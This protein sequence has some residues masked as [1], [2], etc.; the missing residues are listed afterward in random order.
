MAFDAPTGTFRARDGTDLF[1][2]LWEA[3]DPKGWLLA[4]HGLGAHGGWY[5]SLA[6]FLLPRGL[7]TVAFDMRGHG[8]TRWP[9]ASLPSPRRAREDASEIFEALRRRAGPTPVGGVGTSLGGAVLL[10]AMAAGAP[11]AGGVLLSPAMKQRFLPPGEMARIAC[12]LPFGRRAGFPTPLARGLPL[13][14]DAGKQRALHEDRLALRRLPT[15]SWIQA[16]RM[17]AA[18]RKAIDGVRRPLLVIQAGDDEVIDGLE[19]E[20]LFSARENV[21]W[22]SWPGAHDVKLAGDVGDLAGAVAD[23]W[24]GSFLRG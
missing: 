1:Y 11:A 4:L 14:R 24:N 8:L 12:G 19:N 21:T 22:R 10:S 16:A 23:W 20:R 3:R 7:S 13:T 9:L 17:M 2:H 15:M 18:G 5:E 6:A